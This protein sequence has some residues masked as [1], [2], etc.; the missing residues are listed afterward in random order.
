M[1]VLSASQITKVFGGTHALKGVDFAAAAGRVTALF[2]ENGAGKSTLMKIL[3]G[4]ETPTTGHIAVDG[5]PVTFGSA[6]EAADLGIVIIHQELSLCANLSV[7]DNLFLGRERVTGAGAVDRKTERGLAADIL[8]R[9]EEEIDPRTLVGELRLGQ[10]QL[11]EIARALL[12][13]ARVLIMDEPTSALS[14]PEVEVLFR[15]IRELTADGVA[16]VYISHHL[17]EALSIADDVVVLRDGSLVATSAA[18]DV[19]LGWIVRQMVGRDQDSLFPE[20]DTVLGDELLSVTDLV[21]PDP[22]NNDRLAIDGLTVR[23]R[24]GEIVGLYGLMGAGRTEL[25]EAL[26]GR[27]PIQS[28]EVRL[29]GEPLGGEGIRDRISRGLM[30]VPEDR[31]RDGL[32]Q[33]MTVGENLSLA[34]LLAFAKRIFLSRSREDAAVQRTITDVTVK[35]SSPKSPI[36]ALS[37]GNQQKVVIGKALLTEPRVLLLDEPSRGVDV[38]AKADVFALMAEQAR[39]GLAVLFTTS[40]AEEALHIPDRLLVLARGRIVGEFRRGELT[41]EDLMSASGGAASAKQTGEAS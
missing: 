27:I 6:R 41:R 36:G 13:D 18:K 16:V 15:L 30:L 17:D 9:L 4:I 26:A 8:R 29:D 22:S 34:G 38:G 28:G 3:A 23:V 11:V 35:T 32:V 7:E 12:Q 24:A 37:G 39:R 1:S 40:E 2:G 10:Q 19:D 20:R 5:E 14:E 25:L 21:V 33:T 31:Q